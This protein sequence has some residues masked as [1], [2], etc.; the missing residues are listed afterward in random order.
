MPPRSVL[1]PLPRI[2]SGKARTFNFRFRTGMASVVSPY[3]LFETPGVPWKQWMINEPTNGFLRVH[4]NHR[5]SFLYRNYM[6][7]LEDGTN[8][9]LGPLSRSRSIGRLFC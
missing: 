7:E 2:F 5:H 9:S 4:V 8:S 3:D 6:N 1:Q